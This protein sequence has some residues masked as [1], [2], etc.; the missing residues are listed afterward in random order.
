MD[1]VGIAV[2]FGLASL[3]IAGVVALTRPIENWRRVAMRLA[4]L[5]AALL[6]VVVVVRA[7]GLG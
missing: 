3:G 2:I 5:G 4:V 1:L 7:I 6:V